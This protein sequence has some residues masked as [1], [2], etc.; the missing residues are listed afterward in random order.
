MDSAI[1]SVI[2]IVSVLALIVI[3]VQHDVQVIETNY[4]KHVENYLNGKECDQ[5]KSTF[6]Y[7]EYLRNK[8]IWM[9]IS[10]DKIIDTHVKKK[11]VQCGFEEVNP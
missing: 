4:E 7:E 5:Y 1:L 11:M 3:V 8:D 10:L 2:F 9:K 6:Y